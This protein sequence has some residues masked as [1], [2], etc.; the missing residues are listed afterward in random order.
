[1]D[2]Q[3]DLEMAKTI[4]NEKQYQYY[5][6]LVLTITSCK[7][8][9]HYNTMIQYYNII[10]KREPKIITLIKPMILKYIPSNITLN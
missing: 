8:T 2:I 4:F 6:R 9:E 1:M 3:N 10:K 7:T 5:K